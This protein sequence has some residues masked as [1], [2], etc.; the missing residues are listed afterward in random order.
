MRIY[1][2]LIQKFVARVFLYHTGLSDQLGL[3][4]SDLKAIQLLGTEA[5][6]PGEL[7]AK[8]GLTGAAVTALIDRLE[9]AGYAVRQ[10]DRRDRRRVTVH[11][12]PKKLG[13][14]ERLYAPQHRRMSKLLARC[15][16]E[17][18][19]TITDFLAQSTK[20]LE[21]ADR[22]RDGGRVERPPRSKTKN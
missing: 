17:E 13:E 18:F 19:R 14:I 10:R 3:H 16:E 9:Q 5:L 12:N 2:P 22:A 20:M 21:E 11:A 6:S 1:I 8:T 7:G 4:A 15:S